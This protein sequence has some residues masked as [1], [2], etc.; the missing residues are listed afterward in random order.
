M[1][2]RRPASRSASGTAIGRAVSGGGPSSRMGELYRVICARRG[3]SAADRREIRRSARIR[4]LIS[5]RSGRKM[6]G[7]AGDRTGHGA[8]GGS[9][10]CQA[11]WL[12]EL[13]GS[14]G[15]DLRVCVR[16]ELLG[17]CRDAPQREAQCSAGEQELG[18]ARE[19]SA[20]ESACAVQVDARVH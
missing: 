2:V 1:V 12:W 5:R 19:Q 11:A 14:V 18:G 9:G 7:S 13:W 20:G 15:E 16:L 10:G 3:V 17:F 8:W 6:L 4:A